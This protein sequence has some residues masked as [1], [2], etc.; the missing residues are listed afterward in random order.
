MRAV[1]PLIVV[2]VVLSWTLPEAAGAQTPIPTVDEVLGETTVPPPSDPVEEVENAVE[3]VGDTTSGVVEGV[4]SP[5]PDVVVTSPARDVV[6]TSPPAVISTPQDIV[7]GSSPQRSAG[8]RSSGGSPKTRA[9]SP[10]R[11]HKDR[12]G[13]S[14]RRNKGTRG[15]DKPHDLQK[16]A[17]AGNEIF[18]TEVKASTIPARG[19]APL[20]F[21]GAYLLTW[22]NAAAFLIGLGA[23]CLWSSRRPFENRLPGA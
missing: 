3:E 1:S 13:S 20:G 17:D 2:L 21:S 5:P 9:G 6:V 8:N 7:I 11:R 18:P 15:A 16:V 12:A 10:N 14:A 4:L 19:R 22:M 23:L